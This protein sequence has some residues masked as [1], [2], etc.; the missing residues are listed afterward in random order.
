MHVP[1]NLP[2]RGE[3]SR[4]ASEGPEIHHILKTLFLNSFLQ[5]QVHFTQ[6]HCMSACPGVTGIAALQLPLAWTH[7]E[8]LI[9]IWWRADQKIT[10]VG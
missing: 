6:S 5:T 10:R 1:I 7:R 3:S 9:W 8:I 2:S 4:A